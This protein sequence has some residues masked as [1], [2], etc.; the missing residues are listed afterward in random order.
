[1][2]ECEL[3]SAPPLELNS[4]AYLRKMLRELIDRSEWTLMM[5]TQVECT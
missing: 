4:T 1:M 3:A 2:G 5:L